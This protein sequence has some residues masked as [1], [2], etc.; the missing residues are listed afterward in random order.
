MGVFSIMEEKLESSL[1]RDAS[2]E[3]LSVSEVE[4]GIS[5]DDS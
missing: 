2:C 3:I 1:P 4:L 5:K